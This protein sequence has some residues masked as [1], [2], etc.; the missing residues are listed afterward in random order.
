LA[1]TVERRGGGAEMPRRIKCLSI[2]CLAG[3]SLAAAAPQ[4][5]AVT[6]GQLAPGSSPPTICSNPSPFDLL[7]PT[8]SSGSS[9]VVPSYGQSIS[10][11]STNAAAGAGQT[12]ALK[13]FRLVSG[14]TYQVVAHDV[15]RTLVP[16]TI[17]TFPVNLP[18][19]SGDVIGVNDGSVDN[20]C[21]FL[22]PDPLFQRNG[23]LAD[24]QSGTFDS[25]GTT[26][27]VN[28]T[29]IVKPVNTFTFGALTRNKN[30]GTATL[31]VNLPAPGEVTV[32]GKGVKGAAAGARLSKTVSAPGTT[33]LKIKPKGRTRVKLGD[34]G[35]AT[36]KAKV[37]YTPTDGDP[38]TKKR[39]VKLKK[40][41]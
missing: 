38:N 13:V 18:V 34:T 1:A 6:I 15:P 3:I 20:A 8:V 27:R 23:D 28:A 37:T 9:Y 33:K 40:N 2:G 21:V 31:A 39:K 17:N 16:S 7:T 30:K 41:L 5:G 36:V 26:A 19:K 12:L 24:G 10:S 4:A 11:W 14:A 35:K 22:N 25:S 29:A 32:G